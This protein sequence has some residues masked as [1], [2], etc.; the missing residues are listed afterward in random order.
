MYGNL[1]RSP[2]G[3]AKTYNPIMWLFGLVIVHAALVLSVQLHLGL[4]INNGILGVL[5]AMLTGFLPLFVAA[6]LVIQS[7]HLTIVH[8]EKYPMQIIVSKFRHYCS[9]NKAVLESLL[10]MAI[11]TIF[12]DSFTRFKG[13]IPQLN[14]FDWDTQLAQIDRMLHGGV[15]PWQWLSVVMQ[16]PVLIRVVDFSYVIWFV[17]LYFAV[18]TAFF[19]RSH[20][21]QR[22][23]FLIAFVLV[24]GIGGN[25]LAVIFSSAGP[26]FFAQL[27]LGGYYDALNSQLDA[28]NAAAPLASHLAKEAVWNGYAGGGAIDSISAFPSMHVASSALMTLFAFSYARWAGWVMTAFTAIILIGSMVLAWHYAIDGYAGIALAYVSWRAGLWVAAR[29]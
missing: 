22:R 23:A 9:D 19:G 10:S 8:K 29:A 24:W 26:V 1:S 28:I 7:V 25:L 21:M 27:G 12:V 13:L 6:V 2:F 16:Y 14:P 18:F 5:V 17:V 3:I 15:D 20:Q 4:T 11:I